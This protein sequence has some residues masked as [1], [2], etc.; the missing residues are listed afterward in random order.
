MYLYLLLR[1]W[2]PRGFG[3]NGRMHRYQ[4]YIATSGPIF[5]PEP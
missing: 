4:R 5:G 3:H 1:V 2:G